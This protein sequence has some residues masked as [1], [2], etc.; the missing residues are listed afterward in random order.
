MWHGAAWTFVLWGAYQGLAL[1]I[2]RE[3]WIWSQRHAV[4]IPEGW[5]WKRIALGLL[6]FHVTCYGWLIFRSRSLAQ[7]VDLTNRIAG[8]FLASRP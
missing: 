5:N 6:M 1:V 8:G 3:I 7:V 2:A 4:V